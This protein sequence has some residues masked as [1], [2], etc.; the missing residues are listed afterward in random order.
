MYTGM[1]VVV[2]GRDGVCTVYRCDNRESGMALVETG[3]KIQNVKTI[4]YICP[5]GLILPVTVDHD[6]S[7]QS[8]D[9]ANR[10][11]EARTI[12]HVNMISKFEVSVLCAR[13]TP[14]KSAQE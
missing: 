3:L 9:V 12:R 5:V 11:R 8:I 6:E 7:Y 2:L 10:S 1:C 13:R 4:G 14:I